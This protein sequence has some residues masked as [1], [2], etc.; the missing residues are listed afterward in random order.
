MALMVIFF[1]N[2][3]PINAPRKAA[4]EPATTSPIPPFSARI[5]KSRLKKRI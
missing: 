3:E 4:S 1:S 2:F 5:E